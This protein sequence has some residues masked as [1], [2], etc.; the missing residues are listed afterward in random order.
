MKRLVLPLAALLAGCAVEPIRPSQ[1]VHEPTPDLHAI[2]SMQNWSVAGRVAIQRGAQGWSASLQWRK[3]GAQFQLRLVAPLGRGTYQ[4][5]GNS[6]RVELIVPDG[7]RFYASDA[8]ALMDTHLGWSIPVEG[9]E[10]WLRGLVAPGSTPA[11]I[12]RDEAGQLLDME[13]DG[14]RIS[15]LRRVPVNNLSLPAKLFMHIDD[16]KVRIVISSWKLASE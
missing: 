12:N 10:Y 11:F 9:A 16:L 3:S 6:A 14:W 1:S 5:A 2:E 15:V 4:L 8:Q 13:Q 7:G